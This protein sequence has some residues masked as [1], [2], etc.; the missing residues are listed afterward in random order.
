MTAPQLLFYATLIIDGL[1]AYLPVFSGLQVAMQL[2]YLPI[3]R[4]YK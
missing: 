1:L 3:F 4:V 2:A